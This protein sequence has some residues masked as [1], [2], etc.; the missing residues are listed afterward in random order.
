MKKEIHA[1]YIE[2]QVKCSCGNEFVVQSTKKN[3]NLEACSACHPAYTGKT[4]RV[5]SAG[6]VDKFNKKFGL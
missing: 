2:A 5:N 4:K 1:D 3:I 6:R